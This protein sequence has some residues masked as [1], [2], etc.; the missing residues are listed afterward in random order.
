MK[1]GDLVMF[2]GGG[3]IAWLIR[4]W[5]KSS[6]SHCGVLW[7]YNE[8]IMLF[9]SDFGKGVVLSPLANAGY[10]S[11]DIYPTNLQL[12]LN[13]ALSHL[14][15]RYSAKDAIQAG[16]DLKGDHAGWEC[17]E[18]VAYVL[19]LEHESKGWTPQNLLDT[20]FVP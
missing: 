19:G 10:Y 18:F 3:P 4:W 12:D 13:K 14:G 1:T 20:L 8:K 7:V 17:A 5:T 16:I 15:D 2:R 6:W 9:H 11:P